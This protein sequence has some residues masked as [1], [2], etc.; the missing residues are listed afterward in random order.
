MKSNVKLK[1]LVL[2]LVAPVMVGAA[3]LF[4]AD[5]AAAVNW[6]APMRAGY[7][8][9]IRQNNYNEGDNEGTINGGIVLMGLGF[10]GAMFHAANKNKKR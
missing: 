9:H 2:T 4:D 7:R 5:V 10:L 1:V 6:G 8:A 3:L